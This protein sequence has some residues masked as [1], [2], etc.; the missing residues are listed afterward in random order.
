MTWACREQRESRAEQENAD[1]S[2]T[3]AR[4]FMVYPLASETFTTPADVRA[5]FGTTPDQGDSLPGYREQFPGDAG[6]LAAFVEIEPEAPDQHMWRVVWHYKTLYTGER[7]PTEEGYLE[8][9]ETGSLEFRD[10]WRNSYPMPPT[11]YPDASIPAGVSVEVYGTAIDVA[12]VPVS[13]SHATGEI[14]ISENVTSANLPSY[15][16]AW[17]AA[18]GKRNSAAFAGRPKGSLLLLPPTLSKIA[19]NMYRVQYRMPWDQD[20]H[21]VQVPARTADGEVRKGTDGTNLFAELVHWRQPFPLT[22]DFFTLSP[23]FATFL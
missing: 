3:A 11:G 8:W 7:N 5:K 6:M 2:R 1:G 9:G 20:F 12:G 4:V 22:V 13:A 14:T 19:P 15:R 16:L 21:C 10:K 23:N 17:A 18:S